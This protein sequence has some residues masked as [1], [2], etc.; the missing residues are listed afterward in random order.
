[1]TSSRWDPS[2]Y[3]RFG[4]ERTRPFLDLLA[5]IPGGARTVVDLGCGPGNDVA[6]LRA[7]WPEATIHGV[8]SSAEMIE[9]ARAEVADPRTSFEIG[10]AAAWRP[11]GE[12]PDVIVSNAMYQWVDR[13]I[14]LLPAAADGAAH[15][16]AFQ[17]PGNQDAPSHALL[18]RLAAEHGVTDFRRIDVRAPAEYLAALLRPGW[19]VDVWES[20]YLHVLQGE[21][22]V[23]EWIS[24]T[25]ARP[26]L[27]RLHGAEREDFVTRYKAELNIAYPPQD[28]GTVLPF[29]RIFAVAVRR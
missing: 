20:T 25:G 19:E 21:D 14:D 27:A 17:V 24:G 28:F 11:A 5:R 23:F 1:M 3:L 4:D 16:F 12:R 8:D 15:A 9:R 10:D 18:W 26:V 13:H 2:Q 6:P 29:R 7:R 22:A